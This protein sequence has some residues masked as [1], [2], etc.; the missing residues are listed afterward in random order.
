VATISPAVEN[1]PSSLADRAYLA[2]RDRLTTLQIRP[3]EPIEDG[4]VASE[5]EVGR[6][7]VREALKRL[8][9]DRLV[10]SYPRRGTFATGVDITDLAYINEIRVQL[11][12]L[13]ARRAAERATAGERAAIEDL[14]ARFGAIDD[15]PAD[16]TDLMR[17]DMTVHRTVYRAA[18][19]PHLEDVLVRYHNLVTR[20]F[21]LFLERLPNVAEHINEHS[22]IL[23]AIIDGD[24]DTAAGLTLKHVN[25]FEHGVREVI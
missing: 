14:L 10:I 9:D 25:G 8:E 19:N 21:C 16:P 15:L 17:L 7:P 20:I 3:G 1:P 2:L 24:G 13:A 12:P 18:G 4:R 6:T 22:A 23:T 5:L 11:E